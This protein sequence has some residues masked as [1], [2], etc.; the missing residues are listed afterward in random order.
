MGAGLSIRFKRGF[1]FEEHDFA[2][3]S[4]SVQLSIRYN[5][6]NLYDYGLAEYGTPRNYCMFLHMPNT[7]RT[8]IH[9]DPAASQ[10]LNSSGAFPSCSGRFDGFWNG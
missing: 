9:S 4:K 3:N 10:E 6:E 2:A 5:R 1:R 8:H 7:G